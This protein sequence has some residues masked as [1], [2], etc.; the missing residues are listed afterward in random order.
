[1]VAE[2]VRARHLPGATTIVVV[3]RVS[4]A[5]EIYKALEKQLGTAA[6]ERL[7]LVHSRF[8]QQERRAQLG[9]LPRRD[10]PPER[11]DLIVVTTQ[12]LEAG[13]DVSSAV[14]FT[15]LAPW[16]S[17]VQR[18]GRCNRYGEIGQ[19]AEAY[20]SDIDPSE[21]AKLAL[22]YDAVELAS[23]RDRLA[24]LASASPADLPPAD[25]PLPPTQV[26][27]RKDLIELFNTEPDLTGFDVDVSPYIRD[28]D[29]TDVRLF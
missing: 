29:D 7:L 4:R 16:S 3:N 28:A 13:V 6:K 15:E 12:A 21:D 22:P 5:Q 18:F 10:D 8:R 9:R 27:R 17:L 14:L 23:A 2:A 24:G 25:A 26:I 1:R 19:G 20:W 11:K